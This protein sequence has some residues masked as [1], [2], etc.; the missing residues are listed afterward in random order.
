MKKSALLSGIV[1]VLMFL[2]IGVSM[3]YA[4]PLTIRF[5]SGAPENHFLTRQYIEWAKLIEKNSKGD[6]KVEV[7]HSAQ[8]YRDNEVIKAVQTGGVESGGAFTM[9]LENQLVP[10]LKVYM[11]PYLFHNVDETWN[12]YKSDVGA[13]WKQTAERKG[14]KLLAMVAMPSP[15][16]Q[17]IMT[18]KKPVK[19]PADIK[20]LVIRGA[21]PEHAMAIKKWGAG[22]SFL[23]GAE[24][25]MGLQR[26]I[27]NG[28]VNSIATYVDR[29]LYEAAP[30]V[31]LTPISVVHTFIV[32]NKVFFDKL[33]PERQKVIMEASAEIENNTVPFAKKTLTESMEKA[34]KKGNIYLPTAAEALIWREGMSDLWEEATKGNKDVVDVLNKTRII[35]KR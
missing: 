8:L 24:V 34:K 4:E 12:V 16:D 1:S 30:Y 6:I 9:Y 22:P 23:S 29:K 18:T 5:S 20:G 10:A 14:V 3:T 13:G 33:S 35:L 27:I 17:I 32:I 28:A 15:D 25:Y 31:I 21:S 2:L 11:M 26:N 7:Y 19:V